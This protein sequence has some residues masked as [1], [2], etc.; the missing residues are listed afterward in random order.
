VTSAPLAP[1]V[2]LP[3]RRDDLRVEVGAG[4]K[5]VVKDL[6]SGEFFLLGEQ[7]C[8]LLLRLDGRSDAAAVRAAFEE[9]F[10]EP[11]SDEDLQAFLESAREQR[12]LVGAE[13]PPRARTNVLYWRKRLWD[14]DRL[15]SRL[16]PRLRFLWTPA[17]AVLSGIAV[18]LAA[19]VLFANRD[20][21]ARSVADALRW[22]SVVLGWFVLGACGVLHECAHGLTCRHHGGEVREVGVLFLYFMPC[23]YCNVSDAWLFRER[24][25]RMAVMLAGV[26]ADLVV[27]AAAVLLWRVAEPGTLPHRAAFLVLAVEGVGTLFNLIP[28]LK[29]D[30]YY[31]LSDW[32]EVPNLRQRSFDRIASHARRVLWGAPPPEPDPR[33]ALLTGFGLASWAFSLGFLAVSLA[34]FARWSRDLVGPAGLVLTAALV[35]PSVVLFV[36]GLCAGEVVEMIRKRHLRTAVWL[37]LLGGVAAALRHV[38][39]AEVAG[40]PFVVRPA[41]REEVRASVAG[42]LRVVH[43]AEGDRVAAGDPIARIEVVDLDCRLEEGRAELR[44]AQALLRVLETGTRPEEVAEQRSRVAQAE[45]WVERARADLDRMR[46]ALREEL[47]AADALL[48]EAELQREGSEAGYSRYKKLEGSKAVSGDDLEKADLARRVAGSRLSHALAERRRLETRGTID[49]EEELSRREKDLAD[50]RA[51][52]ERMEARKSPDEVAAQRARIERLEVEVRRLRRVEER[53]DVRAGVGGVV[54]TPRLRERAGERIAEGDPICVIEEP[55][56]RHA[57]VELSEQD[58]REVA[59]GQRVTLKARALPYETIEGRVTDIAAAAT[60]TDGRAQGTLVVRVALERDVPALRTSMGGH[61][62]IHLGRRSL[63]GLLVDKARRLLRTEFW[64]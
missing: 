59:V 52:L 39:V 35:A 13:A 22:E 63:G 9:R 45:R 47:A 62:R 51:R 33:G 6:R 40:G 18:L 8:F 54:V 2:P 10:S 31:L 36:R 28:L 38:E 3:A 23:F 21:V 1:G 43:V 64:W 37:V 4:G 12:M 19:A 24:S 58:V 15:F 16:E 50:E 53:L 61:A 60:K 57:E 55:S 30:G 48:S 25:K 7:E 42:V 32:L 56:S 11:L 49:E 14:P 44:E 46:G 34:I 41:V 26:V 17:F 29:L 5:H 20:D 27:W